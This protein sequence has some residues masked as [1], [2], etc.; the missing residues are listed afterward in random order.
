MSSC[1]LKCS[2]LPCVHIQKS[3]NEMNVEDS[4]EEKSVKCYNNEMDVTTEVTNIKTISD[5]NNICEKS[6][7]ELN[8]NVEN[9]SSSDMNANI[10]GNV[11]TNVGSNMETNVNIDIN[12]NAGVA[13][14]INGK[15]S[16]QLEDVNFLDLTSPRQ[17]D[18][19]DILLN[20]YNYYFY[21][22]FGDINERNKKRKE[23]EDIYFY[24]KLSL[25]IMNNAY[26][27][28]HN[29]QDSNNNSEIIENL[30]SFNS[31]ICNSNN[32]FFRTT[33]YDNVFLKRI[34]ITS[35]DN[36]FAKRSIKK[37]RIPFEPNFYSSR[38]FFSDKNINEDYFPASDNCTKYCNSLSLNCN[39]VSNNSIVT[40]SV[41]NNSVNNAVHVS[42]RLYN[43]FMSYSYILQFEGPPP[44]FIILRYN[45]AT[46]KACIV[47]KVPVNK[48]ISF[49]LAKFIAEKYIQILRKNMKKK[50]KKL[51]K[52]RLNESTTGNHI[53]SN[54]DSNNESNRDNYCTLS[55]RNYDEDDNNNN[56]NSCYSST[57]NRENDIGDAPFF[58]GNSEIG[59]I[60][61]ISG[62]NDNRVNENGK[63]PSNVN[64][65]DDRSNPK[66]NNNS[67]NWSNKESSECSV[68]KNQESLNM[69]WSEYDFNYCPISV[70]VNSLNYEDYRI[71][72]L[73]D[74]KMCTNEFLN[75]D[76]DNVAFNT[77][78]EN[79]IKFLS[80]VKI[81]FL[82]K[83]GDSKNICIN[84]KDSLENKLIILVRTKHDACVKSKTFIFENVEDIQ[85]EY[86]YGNESFC[87]DQSNENAT[88]DYLLN[89]HYVEDRGKNENG[90]ANAECYNKNDSLN[91]NNALGNMYTENVNSSNN[92]NTRSS[93]GRNSEDN[94]SNDSRSKG[95][96]IMLEREL[97]GANAEEES[98]HYCGEVNGELIRGH[99]GNSTEGKCAKG[100]IVDENSAEIGEVKEGNEDEI[101]NCIREENEKKDNKVDANKKKKL[102][103]NY[104]RKIINFIRDSVHLNAYIYDCFENTY[105]N[106]KFFKNDVIMVDM[107]SQDD[108]LEDDIPDYIYELNKFVFI[109]F[110]KFDNYVRKNHKI[111]EKYVQYLLQSSIKCINNYMIGIRWIPELFAYEYYVC[112]I[113]EGKSKASENKKNN[114]KH[115]YSLALQ[116]NSNQSTLK[117]LVD[118][119][120][121]IIDN[122]LCVLHEYYQ[123]S[124]FTEKCI[125]NL[126]K[127]VLLRVS[128]YI[129]VLNTKVIT[130]DLD[131]AMYRMKKFSEPISIYDSCAPSENETMSRGE[132]RMHEQGNNYDSVMDHVVTEGNTNLLGPLHMRTFAN[133]YHGNR[134]YDDVYSGVN[135]QVQYNDV[136]VNTLRDRLEYSNGKSD[137]AHISFMQGNGNDNN[138]ADYSR[139]KHSSDSDGN[140]DANNYTNNE[141]VQSHNY[142]KYS[143]LFMKEEKYENERYMHNKLRNKKKVSYNLDNTSQSLRNKQKKNKPFGLSKGGENGRDEPF[144]VKYYSATADNKFVNTIHNQKKEY[145][146]N[147]SDFSGN[148]HLTTK[149]KYHL[150]SSNAQSTDNYS[151]EEY[152]PKINLR[153]RDKGKNKML[154]KLKNKNGLIEPYWW[155][156]YNLYENASI[157]DSGKCSSNST[158]NKDINSAKFNVTRSGSS[159]KKNDGKTSLFR[160]NNHGSIGK[161]NKKNDNKDNVLYTKLLEKKYKNNLFNYFC[162]KKNKIKIKY[163]SMVHDIIYKKF[164]LLNNTIFPRNVHESEMLYTLF[165]HEVHTF[166]FLYTDD[167]FQYQNETFLKNV[168]F[169]DYLITNN[170]LTDSRNCLGSG[171][172]TRGI[173]GD[174]NHASGDIYKEG[175]VPLDE[176]CAMEMHNNNNCRV[177]GKDFY[178]DHLILGSGDGVIDSSNMLTEGNIKF[179]NIPNYEKLK[180]GSRRDVYYGSY[181]KGDNSNGYRGRC[182]IRQNNGEDDG[183]D[184]MN[185]G[186]CCLG[187]M[188]DGNKNDG[189][190]YGNNN[191]EGGIGVMTDKGFLDSS[192]SPKHK[193][194]GFE[195]GK[196]DAKQNEYYD[197]FANDKNVLNGK[198]KFHNIGEKRSVSNTN[199]GRG[200]KYYGNYRDG[201]NKKNTSDNDLSIIKKKKS[202][203][204]RAKSNNL[205]IVKNYN[206]LHN[207]NKSD[208]LNNNG[209]NMEFEELLIPM[210][211]LPTGVYF[212]SARK[213][214]RCQWKENG[215]FKTKGFSLIHYSTLEEARKQCILYR[216]DVGNIPVKSEWLNPDY[217]SFNYLFNKKCASGANNPSISDATPRKELKTSSLNLSRLKEKTNGGNAVKG[218][219]GGSSKDSSD[220]NYDGNNNNMGE[221]A[222][223]GGGGSSS[224]PVD[225]GS[226]GG[227]RYSTRNN[228]ASSSPNLPNGEKRNEID[229]SILQEFVSKNKENQNNDKGDDAADDGGGVDELLR[230]DSNSFFFGDS[231]MN[232]GGRENDR[233]G[234]QRKQHMLDEEKGEELTHPLKRSK[235]GKNS[236]ND[237]SS[238]NRKI[239]VKS[240]IKDGYGG[241]NFSSN[242]NTPLE[243]MGANLR[244]MGNLDNL[245][246]LDNLDNIRN[247]F[248]KEFR[249]NALNHGG[250][251][252]GADSS[253]FIEGKGDNNDFGNRVN[254][255][256]SDIQSLFRMLSYKEGNELSS[257]GN[258]KGIKMENTLERR[259]EGEEKENEEEEVFKKDN[260]GGR[261]ANHHI[262]AVG[263]DGAYRMNNYHGR[264]SILV[265]NEQSDMF[266]HGDNERSTSYR[267]RKSCN[268]FENNNFDF[269]HGKGM[270]DGGEGKYYPEDAD[271]YGGGRRGSGSRG[272]GSRGSGSRGSGSRGSAYNGHGHNI[273]EGSLSHL[274][275][276]GEKNDLHSDGVGRISENLQYLMNASSGGNISTANVINGIGSNK[277]IGEKEGSSAD[278]SK[279]PDIFF[280]DIQNFLNFAREREL[281]RSGNNG[282]APFFGKMEESNSLS[283]SKGKNRVSGNG[284]G[285][286][287]SSDAYENYLKSI[288]VQYEKEERQ[289]RQKQQ[290]QQQHKQYKRQK[291][292]K[293]HKAMRN[294]NGS[295]GS[296]LGNN[297]IGG[298]RD[299]EDDMNS[300][301][302]FFA[303]GSKEEIFEQNGDE[304]NGNS[305]NNGSN[306]HTNEGSEGKDKTGGDNNNNLSEGFFHKY[307]SIF[308]RK[309]NSNGNDEDNNNQAQVESSTKGVDPP[310]IE[311]ETN[312]YNTRKKKK[313]NALYGN[314][315]NNS[316][317]FYYDDHFNDNFDDHFDGNF[318][319]N[320]NEN[321]DNF[322]EN[323]NNFNENYDNFN[324]NGFANSNGNVEHLEKNLLE[325]FDYVPSAS[326]Y[327]N[328]KPKT[329]SS[330]NGTTNNGNLSDSE[331]K[332]IENIQMGENGVG[333]G[334]TGSG[335]GGKKKSNTGGTGDVDINLIKQ[336]LPKGIYY[337]HA[338]KLYRVQYIINNSIKT[339]GFSVKKLGLA[340][341]KIEAE[342]FRNFCLE[343]GLLNS[344][345]RRI[346]SPYNKKEEK[347]FKMI[348]DNEEILSNLL[349]LYNANNGKQQDDT[350]PTGEQV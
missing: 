210:G 29:H 186:F 254:M 187:N 200:S 121:K 127:L 238:I 59:M 133:V 185:D 53:G 331:S 193:V 236:S 98:N 64:G 303:H 272:S 122:V 25:N 7:E 281:A 181:D 220:N 111:A 22:S 191:D 104:K 344:R 76:L 3:K 163:I 209:D 99:H 62:N 74:E 151:S 39:N 199:F 263:D 156:F 141:M 35:I 277:M 282:S 32:R 275:Y 90:I 97:K 262:D 103:I 283:S 308:N 321:C 279:C 246:S 214:W 112:K 47:K 149:H 322:N 37:Y 257:K 332:N 215:K 276:T 253:F 194:F 146:S 81:F 23:D 105:M 349:Y 350:P 184:N 247:A 295:N 341:A 239:G 72:N 168:T 164:I 56:N 212:D 84:R 205:S 318:D 311:K 126:F 49:N 293:H 346:N 115:N 165:P 42:N 326:S 116:K 271:E 190:Y 292:L 252:E 89:N 96:K 41:S 237:R 18:E 131:K 228:T 258:V 201:D 80:N 67:S 245:G 60:S 305:E 20:T 100:D 329:K 174:N 176:C 207:S 284:S 160:S 204:K 317:Y 52:K 316:D 298:F 142:Y 50:E 110:T 319:G 256:G 11:N 106:K 158:R 270:K 63:D 342:S 85:S 222:G 93:S 223:E 31:K 153:S 113:T 328:K 19:R 171:G 229:I 51:E 294:D 289:K 226:T 327:A 340:Q 114:V 128:L 138:N 57:N 54:V 338:K 119:E 280:K 17:G 44:H 178:V 175:I 314:M 14:G 202:G 244:N 310:N 227:N 77:N 46:N 213:L 162:Q 136:C 120:N 177:I 225:N 40:N 179:S 68:I 9:S 69:D 235:R 296:S 152:V 123:T 339:K 300:N 28:E 88:L 129:D 65:S 290:Q 10:N 265:K 82:Q 87:R 333:A 58:N 13:A 144:C 182:N 273:I 219:M 192:S 12:A 198:D 278:K 148:S 304:H 269:I 167:T 248:N 173:I 61:K 241:E 221:G 172:T 169:S 231:Q 34:K 66:S 101:F 233:E 232:N 75:I 211:P 266:P 264:N 108:E 4:K 306:D 336:S 132:K 26:E 86:E 195:K 21:N 218:F 206:A 118:Y 8:R 2:M 285:L 130:L 140:N 259:L 70:D 180:K 345:K 324:G 334:T 71:E 107:T 347:N 78:A 166:M 38:F 5:N 109:K 251:G 297:G 260:G 43:E 94:I 274:K 95:M 217:V 30:N 91:S 196:G 243:N 150:R 155:F 6:S 137:S 216:C 330:N 249:K 73:C 288:M 315:N 348:K 307:L 139:A 208:V 55:T 335:S 147:I 261:N 337:D 45:R 302:R 33:S 255:H 203:T 323:Y 36:K 125:F 230:N 234:R 135:S 268:L 301:G 1:S 183:Y 79:Y 16:M 124:L 92:N 102:S 134:G 161:S 157:Q 24:K 286:N 188:H 159:F 117:Y 343:N 48:N 309:Y 267:K 242:P 154:Y 197:Y 170:H 143:E 83:V 145:Y 27:T 189:E 15:G 224:G 325:S 250:M 313:G 312:D 291:Q 299:M 240:E 320:F 287:L